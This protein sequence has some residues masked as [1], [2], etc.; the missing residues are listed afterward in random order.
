M[1]KLGIATSNCSTHA[2]LWLKDYPACTGLPPGMP[3]CSCLRQR[4]TFLKNVSQIK[5]YLLASP[6]QQVMFFSGFLV[7]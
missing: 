5:F 4:V 1:L 6:R 7:D 2:S 3:A